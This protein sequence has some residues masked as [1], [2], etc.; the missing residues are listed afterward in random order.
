MQSRALIEDHDCSWQS[1]YSNA[2]TTLKRWSREQVPE[3]RLRERGAGQDLEVQLLHGPCLRLQE[4]GTQYRDYY[5]TRSG[6]HS[7]TLKFVKG[8]GFVKA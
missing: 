2:R 6:K 4:G 7:F 1:F 3:L 8:R 5:N